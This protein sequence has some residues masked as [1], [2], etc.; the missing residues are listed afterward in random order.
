MTRLHYFA[1]TLALACAAPAPPPVQAPAPPAS[2]T[3]AAPATSAPP[4]DM[5][6]H[7]EGDVTE[8]RVRGMHILVKRVPGAELVAGNLYVRGGVRNWGKA[9]AG[10][11]QLLFATAAAGGTERM[12][13]DAFSRRLAELGSSIGA[14]AQ[15]DFSAYVAKSLLA[16][17]DTTFDM[18]V[19]AFLRPAL[20]ASEI[21]IQRARQ[22]SALKHEQEDPDGKLSLLV[23]Q[24]IFHGHPYENRAIGTLESVAALDAGK[25]RAHLGKLRETSRLLLVVVGDVAPEHVIEQATR[26]F[27]DVPVGAYVEAPLPPWTVEKPSLHVTEQK[28]PTNYIEASFPGPSWR[29]PDFVV[30]RIAMGVLRFREFQEVRTKRNLSYAPDAFFAS[31]GIPRGGL[32]VTAVDPT[33]TM[34]VMLDEARKLRTQ[35]VPESELAGGKSVWLTDYLVRN[36]ATDGQAA[37]LAHAQLLGGDWRLERTLPARARAVT[38]AQVQA[39][40]NK[41]LGRLQT[42]VLGDPSKVDRALL[43]SL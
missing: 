20:P 28:L 34:K 16:N 13:K 23:H 10:V 22:L 21:E 30:A 35:P 2:A 19:D 36:E 5:A 11:E 37:A 26:A 43:T 39:F 24:T 7:S 33:A 1:V 15:E 32:Y 40:A 41:Y 31:G 6:L 9:D 25:L 18:L 38:S 3:A 29:D 17:W 4:A 42:V 27:A 8:A 12:D 14:G